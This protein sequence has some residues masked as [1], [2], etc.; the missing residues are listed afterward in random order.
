MTLPIRPPFPP[1]ESTQSKTLPAGTAWA[2]EPKWDGFRCIIFRDGEDV[3]VQ[4]KSGKPLARYFPE[5]VAA[6]RER[7]AQRWVLDGEIVIPVE[8]TLSFERLLMR[9]HPAASRVRRLAAETPGLIIAF[10]LL[11][12]ERDGAL[13][14]RPFGERR[15]ALEAFAR[16]EFTADGAFRLSPQTRTVEEARAWLARLAG[17]ADGVMAKRLD[18]P[19][20]SGERTAMRKIKRLRSAECVVTGFR[21]GSKDRLVGSL[22]LS[23]YDEPDGVL[24]PVGYCSGIRAAEKPELTR[25]LEAIARSPGLT[26]QAPGG[27]SRWNDRAEAWQPLEPQL[28]VEVQYDHFSEGR[29][30]HGT[31]I[32]R[33]RPDKAARQCTLAQLIRAGDSPVDLL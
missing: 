23:L 26:G 5:I 3:E 9:V 31:R 17:G 10:D 13:Y 14:E 16:D 1:Q 27:P 28:V 29:F 4:S 7:T 30:R 24:Q 18:M 33:W 25:R 2:Y 20:R 32:L 6:A 8:N 19:Y 15:A 11:Y 21:Y 22:Q 12:T